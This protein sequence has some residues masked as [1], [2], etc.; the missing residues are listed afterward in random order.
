VQDNGEGSYLSCV[1]LF[2][3]GL[4]DLGIAHEDQAAML[5]VKVFEGV[6]VLLLKLMCHLESGLVDFG[7]ECIDISGS[8]LQGDGAVGYEVSQQHYGSRW[9]LEVGGLGYVKGEYGVSSCDSE[10]W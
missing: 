6:E 7:V 2:V 1:H 9:R 4:L 3:E 10:V 5:Q 8:F